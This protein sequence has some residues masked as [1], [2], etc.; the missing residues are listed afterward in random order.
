[1][2]LNSLFPSLTEEGK[3]NFPVAKPRII[4][5][6]PEPLLRKVTEIFEGMEVLVSHQGKKKHQ[7]A[8]NCD[9]G[10]V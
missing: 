3:G 7:M 1:M 6:A 9:E 2:K 8:L 5:H 4:F 10:H